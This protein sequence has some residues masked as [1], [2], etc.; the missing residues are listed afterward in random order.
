MTPLLKNFAALARAQGMDILIQTQKDAAAGRAF[1]LGWSLTPSPAC[2]PQR[3]GAGAARSGGAQTR[4]WH[5][6]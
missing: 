5:R 6:R 3:R 2:T 4:R 1:R